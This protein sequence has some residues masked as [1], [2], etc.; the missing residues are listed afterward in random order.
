MSEFF[1]QRAA[2]RQQARGRAAMAFS[3]LGPRWLTLRGMQMHA[4]TLRYLKLMCGPSR[5]HHT[6]LSHLFPWIS[7]EIA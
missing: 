3:P 6:H 4:T 2:K 7:I 1:F 5:A